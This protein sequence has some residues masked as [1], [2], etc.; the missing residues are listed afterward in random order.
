MKQTIIFL[1]SFYC[2]ST[3]SAQVSPISVG[4]AAGFSQPQIFTK[5][6]NFNTVSKLGWQGGAFARL[7]IKK[8]IVQTEAFLSVN[9]GQVEFSYIPSGSFGVSALN[10]TQDYTLTQVNL[11][12]YVGKQLLDLPL[13][14]WRAY[15]G[16]MF[17]IPIKQKLIISKNEGVNNLIP[18][19]NLLKF[20]TNT[21]WAPQIGTGFDVWNFTVDMRYN[22]AV[23]SITLNNKLRQN[24]F[25][26]TLG[27]KLI[28]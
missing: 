7:T 22:F 9:R 2:F 16:P 12:L 19:N 14:K 25:M 4:P 3:L 21:Q 27:Y 5:V 17:T 23:S 11:P 24:F 20:N 28:G 8:L 18:N 15:L 10:A 13:I 1:L 6:P 26:F